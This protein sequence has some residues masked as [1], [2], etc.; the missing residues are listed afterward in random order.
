MRIHKERKKNY[1]WPSHVHH[2]FILQLATFTLFYRI[3][4]MKHSILMNF[5]FSLLVQFYFTCYLSNWCHSLKIA[6]NGM[7]AIV[8]F[9][10]FGRVPIQS[11]S[12]YFR[13]AHRI[14][15]FH[16][17]QTIYSLSLFPFL[18]LY[19]VHTLARSAILF[20]LE[21][22]FHCRS[23]SMF[24]FTFILFA[25][26]WNG[27]KKKTF[28]L[29]LLLQVMISNNFFFAQ[30]FYIHTHAHISIY[31]YRCVFTM[32]ELF[33]HFT[34]GHK[35]FVEKWKQVASERKKN[36]NNNRDWI[37]FQ[38]SSMTNCKLI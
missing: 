4:Q 26:H 29:L 34:M 10:Y 15:A 33:Q 20:D 30:F 16:I 12:G 28:L 38:L 31:L 8:Y 21:S 27:T 36:H 7:Q 35:I 2:I 3:Q 24:H 18:S 25:Y 37:S 19:H 22:L 5:V 13:V 17:L 14:V 9:V 11:N 23:I 1:T 6:K 32:F